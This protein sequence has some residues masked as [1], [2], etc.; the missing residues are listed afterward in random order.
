MRQLVF[1]GMQSLARAQIKDRLQSQPRPGMAFLI[2]G[3]R[4]VFGQ[5]L[6]QIENRGILHQDSAD[7]FQAF[8]G[9]RSVL[10]PASQQRSHHR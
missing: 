9:N 3:G 5:P 10:H 2:G 7:P 1:A 8:D 4:K 6:V